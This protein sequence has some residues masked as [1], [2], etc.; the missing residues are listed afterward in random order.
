LLDA[1]SSKR[2]E[3]KSK[4]IFLGQ[5]IKPVYERVRTNES[6][7]EHFELISMLITMHFFAGYALVV[8]DGGSI[9]GPMMA[10]IMADMPVMMAE[11]MQSLVHKLQREAQHGFRM[12]RFGLYNPPTHDINTV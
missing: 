12:R 2:N 7:S 1:D 3:N 8:F 4:L 11:S 5:A 9:P 6:F 10:E